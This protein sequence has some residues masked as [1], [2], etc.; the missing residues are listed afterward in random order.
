[1]S[2]NAAAAHRVTWLAGLAGAASLLGG[3]AAEPSF[4]APLSMRTENHETTLAFDT[5]RDRQPDFWQYQCPE[6]RKNAVAYADKSG[7]PG[8]QIELDAIS[9][10]ECPHLLIVLDGVPFELVDELYREG[11]FRFFHPPARVVCCFPAM[12]DLALAELFHT[13]PCVAYEARRFDRTANRVNNGNTSYLGAENSPWVSKMS[14]RCSFWWDVL[15]YLDPKTVFRHELNGT[16]AA[17]RRIDAGEGS[18]YRVGTAGLGTRGGGEAIREYLRT[19][20]RLCEQI[21]YERHGRVKI[22][23]TADHGHNLVENRRVTF[24]AVLKAGGYRPATSLRGPRDVVAISYGLVTYAELFTTDPAGVARCLLGHD[25]V[26]FAC[27]PDGDAVVVVDRDGLA[28]IR[29]AAGGF[30]YDSRE[31]DPLRL[32]PIVEQL[33][34]DGKVSSAGE[35]DGPALFAATVDHYYPDPLARVWGAFHGLVENPPN[36]IVNLRD[37][38]CHGSA[39][40]HTML[41]KVGSTHGSLNRR[42]CTTFVLTML[43]ELPPAMPTRDVWP[44][45][46]ALRG[47]K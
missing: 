7:R 22:T 9:P 24:D 2:S 30:A 32:A 28:S 43:G 4:P 33:R 31:G 39:F 6:G 21:I 10:A 29:K 36:L 3:C 40:F 14:Y 16:M 26:E 15:V 25:D 38:A 19:I 11:Q 1:M 13:K 5:N 46:Q 45:L 27:Y 17:F 35:I 12:T 18:A 42:N 47:E 44:A 8:E 20:D 41:G 23:V 34:R 37:G